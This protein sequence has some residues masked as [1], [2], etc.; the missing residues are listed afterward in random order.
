MFAGLKPTIDQKITELAPKSN[1]NPAKSP[2]HIKSIKRLARRK[3]QTAETTPHKRLERLFKSGKNARS[4]LTTFYDFCDDISLKMWSIVGAADSD[5][6]NHPPEHFNIKI[7]VDDS[8]VMPAVEGER[9]KAGVVPQTF[10]TSFHKLGA[11]VVALLQ[12]NQREIDTSIAHIAELH[13][14]SQPN[15]QSPFIAP[16]QTRLTQLKISAAKF[17]DFTLAQV[18]KCSHRAIGKREQIE[19]YNECLGSP[20]NL[21]KQLQTLAIRFNEAVMALRYEI[22]TF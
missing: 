16:F 12:A 10:L 20:L 11:D 5:M 9:F 1:G 22:T 6:Y 18:S 14:K 15:G 13:S 4:V 21:I 17:A 7:S 2:M 19:D 8:F 3:M